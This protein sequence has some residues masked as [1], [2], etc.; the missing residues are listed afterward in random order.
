VP[1]IVFADGADL[2]Y[3]GGSIR[4][5]LRAE[6]GT[7]RFDAE[8]SE[9]HL[10][11]P[12]G[13][14]ESQMR[15]SVQAW[16]QG[17]ATRIFGERIARFASG[18]APKF[19]GWRLSSARTQWGSCTHDGWVRLNW[20]LVHFSPAVI[21]YVVAHELAHLHELNHSPRFWKAVEQLLPGFEAA[22][23]EIKGVD[24]RSLPL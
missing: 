10:A 20:R 2:P 8:R 6:V 18:I 24:M 22:R 19:A 1:A 13:A 7:T 16:L 9:L 17:E 3:L 15:D 5:R 4:L 12:P 21:D 14:A 23:D 11:L